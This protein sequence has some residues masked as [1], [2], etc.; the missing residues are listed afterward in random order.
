MRTVHRDELRVVTRPEKED[1]TRQAVDMGGRVIHGHPPE[2]AASLLLGLE[3]LAD[4]EEVLPGFPDFRWDPADGFARCW[5]GCAPVLPSRC[6]SEGL[7]RSDVVTVGD[8][9]RRG[10]RV[11]GAYYEER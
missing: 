3:G 5:R 10:A 1:K 2:V 6:L 4:E 11:S 7:E 9:H 8:G